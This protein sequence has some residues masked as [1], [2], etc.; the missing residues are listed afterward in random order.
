[1]NTPVV[2]LITRDIVR[3]LAGVTTGAAYA[4][5]LHVERYV[6]GGNRTRDRLVIIHQDSPSRA[7]GAP[8][9]WLRWLQPY[10]IECRIVEYEGSTV[11]IDERI[12]SIRAD[13]EKALRVDITRGNIAND[14]DIGDPI[15]VEDPE[16]QYA[17][18]I[19]QIVVQYD[20]LENNPYAGR[21]SAAI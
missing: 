20:T 4:N 15:I 14:T 16:G 7:E 13:V 3:T 6:R 10:L 18:I 11:A 5:D 12:N 19:V 1:M 2:E 8:Q 21:G 9:G 17:G